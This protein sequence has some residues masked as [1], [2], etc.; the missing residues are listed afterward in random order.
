MKKI[1]YI[2]IGLLMGVGNMIYGEEKFP[3]Y[4]CLGSGVKLER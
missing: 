4:P 2:L 3:P 1:I